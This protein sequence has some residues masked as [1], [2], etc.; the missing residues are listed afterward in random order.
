[1]PLC[2]A[3]PSEGTSAASLCTL[4]HWG[5]PA[6]SSILLRTWPWHPWRS[7]RSSEHSRRPRGETHS[8]TWLHLS[9]W[10]SST[11]CSRAGSAFCSHHLQLPDC[12]PA[13]FS[14][15]A[16]PPRSGRMPTTWCTCPKDARPSQRRA[17]QQHYPA[18]QGRRC[19][20]QTLL[21]N[22]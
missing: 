21:T 4:S 11:L 5:P 8:S 6:S 16:P 19:P 13:S 10:T 17:A 2:C 12:W 9:G 3:V 15:V 1:M 7:L 22:Q 20:R 14:G 18:D